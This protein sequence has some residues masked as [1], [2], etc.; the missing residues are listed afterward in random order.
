MIQSLL[1]N[2]AGDD[3]QLEEVV[4]R[5]TGT[6]PVSL[7][8]WTLRDRSGLLWTLTGSLAAG[9]SQ[10]FLRGGQPMSLNNAG[11]EI[12]LLDNTGTER[13]R[14]AY[15]TSTESTRITTTH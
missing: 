5:N 7:A 14:F 15:T 3:E 11:D 2:P 1:P 8:G 10:T 9:Q 4:L 12:I 6:A 13:D